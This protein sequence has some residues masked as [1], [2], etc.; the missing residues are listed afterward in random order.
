MT[1][2]EIGNI[3]ERHATAWLKSNGY[4]CYRNTQQPGV[5]VAAIP[6]GESFQ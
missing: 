6:K 3:G 1:P 4:K 5:V 2:A